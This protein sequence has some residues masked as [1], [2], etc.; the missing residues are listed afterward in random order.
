MLR[1]KGA[2]GAVSIRSLLAFMGMPHCCV[3]KPVLD[4]NPVRFC[5]ELKQHSSFVNL[6]ISA[7]A[8]KLTVSTMLRLPCRSRDLR[9]RERACA[10]SPTEA[11][12]SDQAK[13]SLLVP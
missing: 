12:W 4:V 5:K 13:S 8:S 1:T 11:E 6:A 7:A 10:S 3:A 9:E 2:N